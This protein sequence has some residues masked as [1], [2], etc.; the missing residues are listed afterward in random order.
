MFSTE[1]LVKDAEQDAELRQ[2][3]P[4]EQAHKWLNGHR[5]L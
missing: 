1:R 2:L 4:Q 5:S 3:H